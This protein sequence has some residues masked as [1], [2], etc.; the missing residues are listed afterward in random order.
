[1]R[2]SAGSIAGKSTQGPCAA[3]KFLRDVHAALCFAQLG[4]MLPC[5][6]QSKAVLQILL[7]LATLCGIAGYALVHGPNAEPMTGS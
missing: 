3:T 1:M 6:M 4:A 2:H 5:T 7:I